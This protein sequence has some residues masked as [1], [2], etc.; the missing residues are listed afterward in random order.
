MP[1]MD[2]V[3]DILQRVV[4]RDVP[5]PVDVLS[6]IEDEVRQD[7]GGERHYVAKIG[8]GGRAKIAARDRQICAAYQSGLPEDFLSLRYN[9]TVRRIRQIVATKLSG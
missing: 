1:Y 5:L 2:L 4:D 8:E 7:W 6:A 3:S 9:L